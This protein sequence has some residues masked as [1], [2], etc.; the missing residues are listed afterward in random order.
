MQKMVVCCAHF[1]VE[2]LFLFGSQPRANKINALPFYETTIR[3]F[4]ER[5]FLKINFLP[6]SFLPVV[7][8]KN[9][10]WDINQ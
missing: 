9:I 5:L 7:Q 4:D 2:N 6:S 10:F 3:F 1:R 8:L